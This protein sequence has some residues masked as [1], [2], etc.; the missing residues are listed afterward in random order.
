MKNR[1]KELFSSLEETKLRY[2]KTRTALLALRGQISRDKKPQEPL[3]TRPLAASRPL[4]AVDR[5]A[6]S[7]G[8]NNSRAATQLHA[9]MKR[10]VMIVSYT[11]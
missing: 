6:V 10:K 4:P 7:D 9:E 5:P 1:N 2:R 8:K 11:V 3:K